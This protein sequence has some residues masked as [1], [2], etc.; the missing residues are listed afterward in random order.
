MRM[1]ATSFGCLFLAASASA[2]DPNG[3]QLPPQQMMAADKPVDTE[4][5]GHASP[6]LADFYGNGLPD[7]IVGEFYSG[8]MWVYKNVGKP[9]NPKFDKREPIIASG[10]HACVEAG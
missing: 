5:S 9:G 4:R 7:L 1:C 8:R 2:G 3:V 6:F 10:E